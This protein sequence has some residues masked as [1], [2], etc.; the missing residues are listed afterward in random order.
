MRDLYLYGHLKKFGEHF[1]L[2]VATPIEAIRALMVQI[3]GFGPALREGHYRLVV[4]D[5]QRGQDMDLDGL[6]FGGQGPIH[7]IPVVAGAGGNGT[8][9]III[10]VAIAAVAIYAAPAV[11]GA[12]GPTQGLGASIVAG[13]SYGSVAAFGGI[14]A[15]SGIMQML[16]PQ[17]SMPASLEGPDNK[18]SY[19]FNGAVNV[20]E[21]GNA[22]PLV[23]GRFRTGSVVI[24]SGLQAEAV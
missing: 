20:N 7:L 2:E 5:L 15:L 14:I 6:T 1:R 19:L 17:P 18:P 11:V 4:G 24:S 3:K 9:K 16:S 13:I 23:I 21:Q 8:A 12:A 10:G 22:V